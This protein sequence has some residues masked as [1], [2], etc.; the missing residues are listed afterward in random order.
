M[1]ALILA[2]GFGTRLSEET[3]IKPKPMVEVGGKPILW[4]IMKT[5][6]HY[7]VNEFV[8]LLGYKGYC[9]K[10]YF[11]N[12]FLHQSD[13]TI[14][15]LSGNME[16]HNNSSEPWK[17]TLLDT[18]LNV[19]TGARVKKAKDHIGNEPFLL[20]YGDGV[21]DI[22]IQATLDFHKKHGKL[23]TMTAAQP[24]GRFGALDIDESNKVVA[25]KE[26]PK[27]DGSWINA[28]YFVCQPEVLDY[29]PQGNDVVLEQEPLK[30]LAKDGQIYTYKHNDF[31]M[32]MDSLRDKIKLN[33]MCEEAQ[34]APW[35]VWNK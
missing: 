31:W 34:D 23:M 14:D 3:D 10:E 16:V 18:G 27:G 29:I 4:H 30:N 20:T 28:G 13:V 17:V 8:I 15:M 25:F 19:M 1:K 21:A 35:M 6:S 32:P 24:D 26:K 33:E 5:Y 9:I 12:Y 7:G 11:A 2:G 22:N